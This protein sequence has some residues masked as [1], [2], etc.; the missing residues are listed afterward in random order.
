[1]RL[2]GVTPGK[3]VSAAHP[4]HNELEEPRLRKG[5]YRGAGAWSRHVRR[6]HGREDPLLVHLVSICDFELTKRR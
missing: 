3:D 5:D 4:D 6:Q 1:M 2:H